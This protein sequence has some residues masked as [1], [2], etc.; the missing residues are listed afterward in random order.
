MRCC[1]DGGVIVSAKDLK[2]C[3][4]LFCREDTGN[5]LSPQIVR[6]PSCNFASLRTIADSCRNDDEFGRLPNLQDELLKSSV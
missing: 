5:Q 4:I 3:W 6:E 1:Q 2:C